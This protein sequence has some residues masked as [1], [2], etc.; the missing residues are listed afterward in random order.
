ME[1]QSRL[2]FFI[3]LENIG[4]EHNIVTTLKNYKKNVQ[5]IVASSHPQRRSRSQYTVQQNTAEWRDRLSRKKSSKNQTQPVFRGRS[6]KGPAAGKKKGKN[7]SSSTHIHTQ[8]E[9][10]EIKQKSGR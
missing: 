7:T 1:F 10:G 3:F 8:K 2:S 9:G 5:K 6:T 4:K